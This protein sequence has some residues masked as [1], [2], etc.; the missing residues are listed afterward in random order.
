M[1][2]ESIF[3]TTNGTGH[4]NSGGYG[5]DRWQRFLKKV[6]TPN[7][8]NSPG[9]IVGEGSELAVS[10]TA[11]PLTV[12][13]GSAIAD[14][15]FYENTS[16]LTLPV[17][18]PTI[19]PTGG[20]VVLEVNYTAQ[21]VLAKAI[22]SSNGVAAIPNVIQIANTVWQ[23]RLATYSINTS[24]VITVTDVRQFARFG[25]K[26]IDPGFM[27][28]VARL[29]SSAT[30]FGGSGSDTPGQPGGTPQIQTVNNIKAVIGHVSGTFGGATSGTIFFDF[31]AGTFSGEPIVIAN[32]V[33]GANVLANGSA[34]NANRGRI[35]WFSN[36]G[37]G[38]NLLTFYFI[39]I[40]PA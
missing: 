13:S 25:T 28:I 12:G 24:G 6:F 17:S 9:I 1:P 33:S 18:T 7:Q 27:P 10:G 22:S 26:V 39:A 29:G 8:P 35:N 30:S 32:P 37:G 16:A 20:H 31:P 23:V 34:D 4:G 15:F 19:G 14:G 40:G 11:S 36:S 2:E 21:T 5:R 3:W 38:F